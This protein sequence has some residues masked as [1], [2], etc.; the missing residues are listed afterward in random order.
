MHKMGIHG[1]A[2]IPLMLGFGCNVPACLSCRIME[3]Q[4][5]RFITGFLATYIPCSAV[6]VIIL[7]LVGKFMG[8]SWALA[9]YLFI[10]LII[11][12]LGR[13]ASKV[14]PG[15]PMELIMNMPDYKLP[16][17]K[18]VITKTWFRLKEFIVIA[19]PLVII[20]GVIIKGF[21][22]TGWLTHLSGFL[23]PVTVQWLGLP[24][25]TG[26]L[27]IFGILRKELILVMLSVL[28][29]TS[30]FASVLS[31]VQMLTLALVSMLYIP[32]IATISA[33]WKEFGW[34]RAL[35]ITAF[36]IVFA[37]LIAG[38]I[39]KILVVTLLSE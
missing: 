26:I 20:S 22:L 6:T 13:I 12:I 14:L 15:E 17:L 11:F 8:I 19:A 23:S 7:G 33:L 10:F 24:A 2:S 28:L 32:C 21:Y 31:P 9:L 34:K 37:V 30:D 27:L 3:T 4:R 5:E 39:S 38:F 36:K 1:K 18:S 35:S 25:I 16:H 29:G